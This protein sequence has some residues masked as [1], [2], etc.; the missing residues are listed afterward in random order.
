MSQRLEDYGLNLDRGQAGQKA[1]SAL[2]DVDSF[3]AEGAVP[4]GVGVVRGTADHQCAVA[5]AAT[6]EF[7]GVALFA[8]VQRQGLAGDGEIAQYEDTDP[9]SV[10]R[11]GPV[12]VEVTAAVAAGDTAHVDVATVGEEGKFTNV[13]TANLGPV[14]KFKTSAASGELAVVEIDALAVGL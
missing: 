6:D 3:A 1:E 9:V 14:G 7:V 5:S 13:E 12:R 2:D 8:H 11:R 10:L 4:F